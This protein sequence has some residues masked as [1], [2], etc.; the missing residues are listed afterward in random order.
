MITYTGNAA[1]CF[2]DSLHK[3]SPPRWPS[4]KVLRARNGR[5]P[6]HKTGAQRVLPSAFR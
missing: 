6:D 4:E 5:S 3:R 1:Y 2:S